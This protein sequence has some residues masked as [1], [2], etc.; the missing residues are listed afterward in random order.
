MILASCQE[1]DYMSDMKTSASHAN[2]DY[3]IRP[4][5][6]V[7]ISECEVVCTVMGVA[8]FPS[9]HGKGIAGCALPN[10]DGFSLLKVG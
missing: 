3:A 7:P 1:W 2:T 9:G 10:T 4:S 8:V 5:F 6:I